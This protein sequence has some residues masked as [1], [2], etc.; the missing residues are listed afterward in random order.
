MFWK[1]KDNP[2]PYT[3]H[4]W[5]MINGSSRYWC[6]ELFIIYCTFFTNIV[7]HYQ[8]RHGQRAFI[9][10]RYYLPFLITTFYIQGAKAAQKRERNDKKGS[11]DPK[12]QKKANEAS[13]TIV[14]STCRQAFVSFIYP[15]WCSTSWSIV[16]NSCL[17]PVRLRKW[18]DYLSKPTSTMGASYF[19]SLEEHAANRH[20]KTIADC[21]PDYEDPK[22]KDHKTKLSLKV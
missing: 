5:L 21:F 13:K 12:S 9:F 14:C 10:K 20:S 2:W 15:S 3:L 17:L 4:S 8:S 11:K 7:H 22:T 6:I 1:S 16:F 18:L 19:H